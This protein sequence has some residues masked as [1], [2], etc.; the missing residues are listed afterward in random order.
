V[1]VQQAAAILAA[2][3]PPLRA[4][5][6]RRLKALFPHDSLHGRAVRRGAR[7][8]TRLFKRSA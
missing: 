2:L 4:R 3:T 5:L 6:V 8:A 1:Q 7:L